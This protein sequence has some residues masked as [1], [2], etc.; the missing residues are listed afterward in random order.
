MAVKRLVAMTLLLLAVGA[1]PAQGA[2]ATGIV[3]AQVDGY[4]DPAN[5][6]LIIDTIKQ[7][8]RDNRSLVVLQLDSPGALDVDVSSL[9]REIT[10]ASVPVAVWVG[11]SGAEA[12]GAAGLLVAAAPAAAI[13]PGAHVGP[14]LPVLSND[15]VEFSET[16]I[17]QWAE[18]LLNRV[19]RVNGDASAIVN[20]RLS[21]S[22]VDSARIVDLVAPTVG[23]FIVALDDRTLVVG[24]NEIKLGTADVTGEGLDARQEPN[25]QVI[26]TRLGLRDQLLHKLTTP[27]VAYFFFIVGLALLV[28]EFFTAS[29]GLAGLVGAGVLVGSFVGFS[30]LPVQ[31]WAAAL[32]AIGIFGYAIDVQAGGLGFWTITGFALTIAGSLFLYGGSSQLDPAWWVYVLVEGALALFMLGGM[33]SIIRTRFSTP[34]I[35]RENLVGQLGVVASDVDPDGTIHIHGANWKAR[36]NRATPVKAGDRARVVSVEGFWLEIEPETGGARD[37]HARTHE[38]AN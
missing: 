34:T 37:F 6:S 21:A 13:A 31:W 1:A 38:H 8:E 19:G 15:S 26:F 33:T 27:E 2:D 29:I 23:E 9:I 20:D 14:L 7:A 10:N 36:T 28:F 16:R 24:D 18:S 12:R 22:N 4:I 5:V 17:T 35:G 25:Q 3:V 30:H 11:P 32:I